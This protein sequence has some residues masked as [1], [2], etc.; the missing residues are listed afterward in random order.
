MD[1]TEIVTQWLRFS[2]TDLDVAKQLS[3]NMNPR[4][5]EI[6]CFHSQQS[7]EKALKAFLVQNDILPPKTHDLNQLC[8]M[9][10][11]IDN[12]FD[13]IA[14]SCGR[15]NRYSVMPRYPYEIDITESDTDIAIQRASEIVE[16]INEILSK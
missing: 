2:M 4:P 3:G 12:S 16:W 5:L 14:A 6:I 9:C 8:E 15:L 11:E 10:G 13:E 7:A 1:I